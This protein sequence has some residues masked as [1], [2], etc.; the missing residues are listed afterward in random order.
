MHPVFTEPLD[1]ETLSEIADADR[2][3][4]TE[5]KHEAGAMM[6]DTML[7]LKTLLDPCSIELRRLTKDAKFDWDL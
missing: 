4:V 7:I 1:R 2:A 3:R 6:E 5:S